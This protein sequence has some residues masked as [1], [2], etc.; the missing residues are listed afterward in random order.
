MR[1]AFIGLCV[2]LP[3]SLSSL[4]G[5]TLSDRSAAMALMTAGK[6]QEAAD[7]FLQLQEHRKND[8][9]QAD[10][11]SHAALC[12]LK[13]KRS[14][15]AMELAG[16][17]RSEPYADACRMDLLKEDRQWDSLFKVAGD[18]DFTLWPESL[19]Y[20]A[21]MAR[22]QA[23]MN[24]KRSDEAEQDFLSAQKY[25][26]STA[27]QAR[28]W[29]FIADNALRNGGDPSKALDA[30]G[31]VV[32]LATT[33]GGALQKAYLARAAILADQKKWDEALAEVALLDK[34]E[35]KDNHW[36]CAMHLA[37]GDIYEKQGDSKLALTSYRKALATEKAP[38]E[39]VQQANA[40]IAGLESKSTTP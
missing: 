30:Y 29:S 38:P 12:L 35:K 25:T 19:I 17:I 16:T 26:I 39:L 34:L 10:A 18:K 6:Y 27:N 8:L 1:S 33:S 28:A 24:L 3:L 13:L 14:G 23:L 36:V 40:K 20:P 31:Q 15:E 37:Y 21:F 9:Q 4:F 32:R 11:V 2:A 5:D 22:G 7:A